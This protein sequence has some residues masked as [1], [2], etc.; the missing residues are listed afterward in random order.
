MPVTT[1]A[2]R[3]PMRISCSVALAGLLACGCSV[4]AKQRLIATALEGDGA[5]AEYLEATLQV[6]DDNPAY[7]DELFRL[8]REHP[9]TLQRF[10][11][12][13]AAGLRDPDL[14]SMTARQLV[15]N[16][17]GLTEVF[18]RTLDEAEGRPAAEEAIAAAIAA[19]S[20]TAAGVITRDAEVAEGLLN[21]TVDLLPD[22]AAA[23]RAFLAV[24]RARAPELLPLVVSDPE[25]LRAMLRGALSA[26]LHAPLALLEEVMRDPAGDV[27]PARS[28][29]AAAGSGPPPAPAGARSRPSPGSSLS[30]RCGTSRSPAAPT[31]PA[32]RARP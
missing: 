15:E 5:R 10:L 20:A 4:G 24:M 12:N 17:P 13:A 2:L 25:T 19:R 26:G 3:L 32:G 23:R 18:I 14:A 21:A 16:P 7:V 6:L 27:S 31:R 22:R 30:D 8:A 1:I 9:R 28:A 29:P 11:A